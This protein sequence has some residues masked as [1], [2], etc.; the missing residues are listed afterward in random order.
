MKVEVWGLEFRVE[1][2]GISAPSVL[3]PTGGLDGFGEQTEPPRAVRSAAPLA[4]LRRLLG[5]L[6]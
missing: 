5:G 1:G 2:L 6:R 4:A 3:A